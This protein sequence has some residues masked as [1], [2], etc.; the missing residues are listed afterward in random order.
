MGGIWTPG[1][2]YGAGDKIVKV[3]WPGLIVPISPARHRHLACHWCAEIDIG[4]HRIMTR[5]R[6]DLER[7]IRQQL[8]KGICIKIAFALSC[9]NSDVVSEK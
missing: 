8:G 5:P 4:L 9:V 3:G 7:L 2:S 1:E 6:S